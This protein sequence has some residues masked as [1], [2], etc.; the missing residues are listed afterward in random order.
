M[1]FSI[2]ALYYSGDESARTAHYLAIAGS[3]AK[4]S[5]VERPG[6]L[7][8]MICVVQ[9]VTDTQLSL[10][11]REKVMAGLRPLED[12]RV[13]E[14]TDADVQAMFFYMYGLLTVRMATISQ[15]QRYLLAQEELRNDNTTIFY[16]S[17]V[18]ESMPVLALVDLIIH[19]L[20]S[21]PEALGPLG[22]LAIVGI[23]GVKALV[24]R[25]AGA[26]AEGL[27]TARVVLRMCQ[28]HISLIRYFSIGAMRAVWFASRV[29]GDLGCVY[30]LEAL[31]PI[32]Q[33][34]RDSTL[35]GERVYGCVVDALQAASSA[36]TMLSAVAVMPTAIASL[37]VDRC[38][39]YRAAQRSH[40]VAS[41]A[42]RAARPA[43]RR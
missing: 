36:A 38:Q 4:R 37:R 19:L 35:A 29:F 10:S 40:R 7:W 21:R 32:A 25:N 20:V 30:E 28:Q 16:S 41:R 34:L 5:G 17:S 2:L 42:S 14:M 12:K 31:M 43:R 1:G 15:G 22:Y 8:N 3:L 9:A 6:P 13:E 24:L 39:T 27:E 23:H 11:E 33:I 18:L 26:M